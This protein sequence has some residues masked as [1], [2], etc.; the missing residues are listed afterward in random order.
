MNK[1]CVQ[2]DGRKFPP[3]LPGFPSRL[4]VDEQAWSAA[5]RTPIYNACAAPETIRCA[6]RRRMDALLRFPVSALPHVSNV[7]SGTDRRH[8]PHQTGKLLVYVVP[9][10]HTHK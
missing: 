7:G 2:V 1:V 9:L 8:L 6:N 5:P 3:K 4:P 10:P